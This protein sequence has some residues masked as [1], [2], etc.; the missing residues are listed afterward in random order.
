MVLASKFWLCFGETIL[1][2][3]L[4]MDGYLVVWMKNSHS[5]LMLLVWRWIWKDVVLRSVWAA[6]NGSILPYHVDSTTT[7]ACV[8]VVCLLGYWMVILMHLSLRMS[9]AKGNIWPLLSY[10]N[11]AIWQFPFFFVLQVIKIIKKW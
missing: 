5:F 4:T 2:F 9:S 7:H 6:I 11:L 1:I 10:F 3:W 8:W